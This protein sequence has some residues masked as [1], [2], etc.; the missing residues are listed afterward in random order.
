[1][2][3]FF[4]V[5]IVTCFFILLALLLFTFVSDTQAQPIGWKAIN[6]VMT[7]GPKQGVLPQATLAI[8]GFVFFRDFVNT[9]MHLHP[10]TGEPLP[11]TAWEQQYPDAARNWFFSFENYSQSPEYNIDYTGANY[12]S[13]KQRQRNRQQRYSLSSDYSGDLS[14]HD[15][16]KLPG[17]TK[18]PDLQ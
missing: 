10:I 18:N 13:T 14:M 4:R 5:T 11:P 2:Q 9:N 1:M 3:N 15:V 16:M 17:F 12:T 6:K 8:G 7:F